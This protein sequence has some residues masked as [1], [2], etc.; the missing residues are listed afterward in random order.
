MHT[1]SFQIFGWCHY[2]Y[3]KQNLFQVFGVLYFLW[4]TIHKQIT[5]ITYFSSRIVSYH[6]NFS[7]VT[8]FCLSLL[9]RLQ[10]TNWLSLEWCASYWEFTAQNSVW[11]GILTLSI[12]PQ[13]AR[14]TFL[15]DGGFLYD[16]PQA[17]HRAA[18]LFAAPC[19]ALVVLRAVQTQ[20]CH[21]SVPGPEN[22]NQGCYG[23]YN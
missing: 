9:L 1:V 19:W 17:L 20:Q 14:F 2:K 10:L 4:K 22:P 8:G 11:G 6:I 21:Y 5:V 23:Q 12:V 15:K 13:T 18:P 7:L 16:F 3:Y